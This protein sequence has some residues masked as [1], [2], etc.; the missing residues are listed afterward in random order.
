MYDD[1]KFIEDL[2]ERVTRQLPNVG[3]SIDGFTEE[4]FFGFVFSFFFSNGY[5]GDPRLFTQQLRVLP[6]VVVNQ[7]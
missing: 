4:E 1:D 3:Y 6:D 5:D 2:P 7:I